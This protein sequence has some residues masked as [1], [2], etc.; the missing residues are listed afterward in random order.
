MGI[1]SRLFEIGEAKVNSVIDVLERPELML[2]QAIRDKDKQIKSVK[3]SVQSCITTERQTKA[4]LDREKSDKITWEKKAK[5]A[6]DAGDEDLAF[7]SL[8]RAAEHEKNAQTLE[9]SWQSQRSSVDGLKQDIFE[10]EDELLKFKRNKYFIIAQ[11]KTSDVKKEIYEAKARIQKKSSG[12]D[13]MKR[14]MVKAQRSAFG[15][16]A[17]KEMAETFEGGDRLG[18][19]I[20]VLDD[21][22]ANAE[23]Q[24][25]LTALKEELGKR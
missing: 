14:M 8:A 17:A 16:D 9:V 3:Q 22:S 1:F 7:R 5:T 24:R 25:K 12:D 20:E 23:T 10:L 11:S 18:K 13:L 2:E 4:L 6:L 21:A 19:E 15:A